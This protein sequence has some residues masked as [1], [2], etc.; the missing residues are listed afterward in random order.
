MENSGNNIAEEL[1]QLREQY[2]NLKEQACRQNTINEKSILSSVRRDIRQINGKKWFSVIAC[3]VAIPLIILISSELEFRLPFVIVSIVW[4][5]FMHIG[6]WLR[7]SDVEIDS[8]S[9]GTVRS[10]VDEMKRRKSIQFKWVR[11][12]YSIFVLWV[13]YFIGEC[14]HTGMDSD[15]LTPI[16]GGIC[17][18][19]IIGLFLGFRIHNRI[20]GIYDGIILE[21]EG[22][23]TTVRPDSIS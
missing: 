23:A 2:F 9:A 17:I 11:I 6:N 13:G 20:I 21:L 19:A 8:L 18:G 12:N 16:I 4:L 1:R 22:Q 10:F 5:L 15:M 3:L 14:I 7:N